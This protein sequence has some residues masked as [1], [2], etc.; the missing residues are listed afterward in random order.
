MNIRTLRADEIECRVQQVKQN[1]CVLLLYKDARCDMRILDEVFQIDGWKREHNLIDGKL[2][3][4]VSI[5]SDRLNQWITK[6]D[7]G[8]E[9]NTEKEKGQ[10]SDSFKRACFNLGIGRELY[11][12]PFTWINLNSN[13]V[14]QEGNKYKLDYKVK[15]EVKAIEYNENREI[16]KLVIM[17]Q[18]GKER[19]T[20]NKTE[21][22]QIS[23]EMVK[24]IYGM[25]IKKGYTEGQVDSTSKKDYGK[26]IL[27]LDLEEYKKLKDKVEKLESKIKVEA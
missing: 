8:T 15:F 13:E 11:S 23:A 14:K 12:S 1:G 26:N 4:T 16:S 25:A 7:V 6:Q 5:W 24:T 18:N 17:D 21:K 9:S 10:A 19:F 22:P 20:F 27:S 2:F 3:C